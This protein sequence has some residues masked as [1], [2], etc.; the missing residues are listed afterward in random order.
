MKLADIG[1]LFTYGDSLR[2]RKVGAW[3][4]WDTSCDTE[5]AVGDVRIVYHYDTEM[6]RFHYENGCWYFVPTSTGWG[7]ASDQQGMNKILKDFGWCYRRNGGNA[8]YERR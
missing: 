6:G 7:S 5:N 3:S 8:R 2:P 4:Y 1:D